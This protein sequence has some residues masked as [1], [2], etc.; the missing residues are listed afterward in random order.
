MTNL[1]FCIVNKMATKYIAFQEQKCDFLFLERKRIKKKN[2]GLGLAKYISFQENPLPL[3][4]NPFIRCHD[5]LGT[6]LK[7][8]VLRKLREVPL[9][10]TAVVTRITMSSI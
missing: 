4:E 6:N 2:R 1:V 8:I 9:A 5:I 7:N 3:R 10:R